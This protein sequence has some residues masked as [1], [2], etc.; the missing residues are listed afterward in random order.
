MPQPTTSHYG[1]IAIAL[2]WVVAATV[3]G[4]F[5]LGLWMV[6]LGYYDPW[7]K[8]AP[9]IHKAIGVLLFIA[10][11]A[12]S[13]WRLLHPPPTPLATH[14]AW[15]RRAAIAMHRLLYVLL[16]ATMIAGYLISTAD[17]RS[18]DVFGWFAVPATVSGLPNQEDIAGVI[19]LALAI[20][21]V[22]LAG[23]H[24]LAALKHHFQDRDSTLLR[25]LGRA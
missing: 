4:M 6:D 17:G 8:A 5:A 23:V 19:H 25:M 7:R 11:V 16:F 9:E 14:A 15:E 13:A 2:H 20:T 3:I 22:V 10:M 18:I 21:V 24:A 12:R 1:L